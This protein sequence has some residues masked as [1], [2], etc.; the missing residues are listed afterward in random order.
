MCSLKLNYL[1]YILR[2]WFKES[3]QI[4]KWLNYQDQQF[5][6]Y[7]NESFIHF[8]VN[9]RYIMKTPKKKNNLNI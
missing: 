3:I 8:K 5:S 6:K 4:N 9:K 1:T 2:L 7:H